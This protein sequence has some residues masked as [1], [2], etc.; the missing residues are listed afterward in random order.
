MPVRNSI[1][2]AAVAALAWE[3]RR[4][5]PDPFALGVA[6]GLLSFYAATG[7]TRAQFGVEQSGAGRYVYE[8]ALL[9]VLLLADAARGLPWRGTW[10]PALAA[11]VFLVCFNSAALLFEFGAAKAVQMQ[12]EAADL[13]ALDAARSDPCLD[14]GGRVDPFVMP[15]GASPPLYYR[16][17]DRYGDPAPSVPVS[18]HA[19]YAA[20]LKNLQRPGCR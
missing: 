6:A 10:R 7:L 16:A 1:R 8:G 4:R 11:C 19:D 14:A 15:Q 12:R 20:A 18:D 3:W 13:Q 2:V 5:R 17:I 9:L